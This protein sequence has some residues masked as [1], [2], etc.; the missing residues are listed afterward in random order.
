VVILALALIAILLGTIYF[1]GGENA[2]TLMLWSGIVMLIFTIKLITIT[3]IIATKIDEAGRSSRSF[4]EIVDSVNDVVLNLN[5]MT[6]AHT[7]GNTNFRLDISQYSGIYR[8]VVQSL[9]DMANMY[10]SIIDDISNEKIAIQNHIEIVS[11]EVKHLTKAVLDGQ[12]STRSNTGNFNGHEKDILDNFNKIME[13]IDYPLTE[14]IEILEEMSKGNLT[15]KMIG[16]Y[17]G[18]FDILETTLNRTV[19]VLFGYVNETSN[20]LSRMARYDLTMHIDRPF[21]GNFV[22]IQTSVNN[23]VDIFHNITSEIAVVVE[24]LDGQSN[25]VSIVNDSLASGATTQTMLVEEVGITMNKLTSQVEVIT[26]NANTVRGFANNSV[27]SAALGTELLEQLSLAIEEIRDASNNIVR[28]MNAIDE[29]AF[30]TNMLALNASVE[31][32]RAGIHGKGFSVVAE[33]V[34]NLANHSAE[35]SKESASYVTTAVEKIEIGI[36]GVVETSALFERIHK[37]ASNVSRLITSIY[38]DAKNQTVAFANVT[39]DMG[40][41]SNISLNNAAISQENAAAASE[42][43]TQT[44]T[45]QGI[46]SSFKL[47]NHKR[48]KKD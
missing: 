46:M 42:L 22:E 4:A 9:N 45:L 37:N 12:T 28:T 2:T 26:E 38:E 44:T 25:Q 19:D 16:E 40:K 48:R 6:K 47:Q 17:N 39:T 11:K 29:I 3:W 1:I 34:R 15:K 8:K 32:A 35:V 5:K 21:S 14:A 24:T 13:S 7:E 30:Q 27:K 36:Q 18:S 10:V 43:T 41:I 20:V 31:A 33:E 23:I